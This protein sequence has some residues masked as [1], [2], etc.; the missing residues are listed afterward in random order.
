MFG[1]CFLVP[2]S[3]I[4]VVGC[5]FWLWFAGCLFSWVV[6]CWLFVVGC[7]FLADVVVVF[8]FVAGCAFYDLHVF[9]FCVVILLVGAYCFGFVV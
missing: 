7:W 1:C 3:W 8:V 2:G 6:G 5:W 4:L 9:L